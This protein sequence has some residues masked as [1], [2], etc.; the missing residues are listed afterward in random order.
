MGKIRITKSFAVE[1]DGRLYVDKDGQFLGEY[2][3]GQM[4]YAEHKPAPADAIELPIDAVMPP[5]RRCIW[6][7]GAWVDPG[8]TAEESK[9]EQQAR[10]A[11]ARGQ[12]ALAKLEALGITADD[13]R[14]A[15]AAG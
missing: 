15:L 5:L 6:E 11:S 10:E 13:I 12:A 14:A 1:I 7:N 8:P 3:P 2:F 4:V 9:A